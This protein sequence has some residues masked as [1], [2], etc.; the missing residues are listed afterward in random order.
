MQRIMLSYRRHVLTAKYFFFFSCLFLKFLTIHIKVRL[1]NLPTLLLWDLALLPLSY[2]AVGTISPPPRECC[3]GLHFWG[4]EHGTGRTIRSNSWQPQCSVSKRSSIFAH[5]QDM[6]VVRKKAEE[7]RVGWRQVLSPLTHLSLVPPRH[8]KNL[9]LPEQGGSRVWDPNLKWK[10][11]LF[12]SMCICGFYCLYSK[13]AS[14]AVMSKPFPE[15]VFLPLQ[16]PPWRLKSLS[17]TQ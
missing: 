7:R 3:K 9:T 16:G 12:I 6:L 1:Q 5:G 2:S 4:W 15:N 14:C 17:T 11:S 10:R 13:S 8:L